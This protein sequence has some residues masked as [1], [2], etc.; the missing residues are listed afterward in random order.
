[1]ARGLFS[2]GNCYTKVCDFDAAKKCFSELYDISL[3]NNEKIGLSYAYDGF[4][5]CAK[6]ACDFD[7][8]LIYLD[9]AYNLRTE[10][11]DLRGMGY[12]FI[13]I[14]EIKRIL[15]IFD[16]SAEYFKK[17]KD[18]I[19]KIQDENLQS[20]VLRCLAMSEIDNKNFESAEL[21]ILQS[22]ELAKKIFF[23]ESIVKSIFVFS[24]LL[25]KQKKYGQALEFINN[26]IKLSLKSGMFDIYIQSMLLKYEILIITEN[27]IREAFKYF[28]KII[29]SN[30][31]KKISLLKMTASKIIMKYK[32]KFSEFT[33]IQYN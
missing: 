22:L 20:D 10:T 12:S 16:E 26:N 30:E 28:E 24:E 31:A 11:G 2:L 15:E 14:G 25:F 23:H 6:Y 8:A 29:S 27:K 5:Y 7:N 4:A 19:N 21:L 1:V 17:A 32:K 13:S 33:S 3:K 18:V 9:K